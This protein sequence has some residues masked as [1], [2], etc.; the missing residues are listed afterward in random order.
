[1]SIAILPSTS[2]RA[3]VSFYKPSREQLARTEDA[4]A[5][6]A[7]T[8]AFFSH[9]LYA[10]LVT[11]F[12]KEVPW[13]GT[14]GHSI[15]ENL[16]AIDKEGWGI[17]ERAFVKGHEVM[18]YV[19][20]DLLLGRRWREIGEVF[21]GT[22]TLPYIHGLMNRASDYVINAALIKAKIG[23]M[24]MKN[25]KPF[26]LYDPRISAEGMEDSVVIYD[27]L[28]DSYDPNEP[29]G[30]DEH[31]EPSEAEK[32]LEE[33]IGE[34]RRIQVIAGAIQAQ[35]ASGAG[36]LPASIKRYV[37]EVL[38]PKVP[39]GQHLRATM[40]RN[41][42][43][44]RANPRSVNKKLIARPIGGRIVA[45]AR[46]KYG[47]G[48][49]V[50]GWDTSGSTH[51][52]QTAFF[53]EM[54]GIVADLKPERLIVVRCDA[55]VHDVDELERPQDLNGLK[56]K[57]NE[58]GIGGGGGTRFWPVFDWIKEHNVK[59]DMLVY[60]TDMEGAFPQRAPDYSTIW[61]SI[62]PGKRAPFGTIVEVE[63]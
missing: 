37:D 51:Q 50:I 14:D 25:G 30:F 63:L 17:E 19:R 4:E 27:Q 2:D 15:F 45:A 23:R 31:Y 41:A 18:H 5:F 48:T 13:A 39:W 36:D 26:G 33:R 1:M 35:A 21:T 38:D 42:G 62:K 24:P 61:A 53:A 58:D 59:P 10:E 32:E 44:P 46:S 7:M 54:S 9:I 3:P 56:A 57:V 8:A 12:T 6:L 20:G 43:V 55:K 47:C 11:R 40:V 52:H 16:D 28:F 22:R 34:A 60:L 49:I 29:D